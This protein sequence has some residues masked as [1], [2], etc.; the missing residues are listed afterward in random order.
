[1]MS[2]KQNRLISTPGPPDT[3]QLAIRHNLKDSEVAIAFC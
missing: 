2:H 3:S 1:M